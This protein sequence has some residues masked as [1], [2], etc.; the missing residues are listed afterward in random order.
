[1]KCYGR[2]KDVVQHSNHTRKRRSRR[3]LLRKILRRRFRRVA[4]QALQ[5]LKEGAA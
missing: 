4:K 5:I 1:M 2:R 3:E